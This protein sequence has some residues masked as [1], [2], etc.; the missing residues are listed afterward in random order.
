MCMTIAQISATW[1]GITG[2]TGY[3]FLYVRSTAASPTQLQTFFEA[4][5]TYFPAVLNIQV[6]NTGRLIDESN[7]K[8]TGVWG[9]GATAT[10]TGTGSS[11]YSGQTGAQVKW[12]T[13]GFVNGRHVRGR[14]F[15]VPLSL[16]NWGTDGLLY[17]ATCNAINAAA[18]TMISNYTGNLVVWARPLF[19]KDAN[20]DPTDVIKR[21]GSIHT[22][23][24]ATTP[25]KPA[26][27]RGRRD[28]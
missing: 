14:T 11:G 24:T 12:D 18:T 28:P 16:N 1:T 13:N 25:R 6:P 7:G 9:A 15:L 17:A 27:L 23:S 22:V 5:K 3:T 10:T 26:T 2:G 20:G 4:I 8:M 19:E 21:A